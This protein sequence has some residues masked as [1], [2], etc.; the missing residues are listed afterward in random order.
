MTTP[1]ERYVKFLKVLSVN[2]LDE[3]SQY[4]TADVHFSD[5]FNDVK[6]V[7]NM[8]R[9]LLDMFK[10]V[11]PVE[12]RILHSSGDAD[13]GVIVWHFRAHLMKKPWDFHGTSVLKFGE[14]GRVSEHVDYWDAAKDFYEHLPIIGWL[15]GVFRRRLAIRTQ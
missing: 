9:V 8:R 5:P 6:G 15:L 11:G 12:F 7:E 1:I 3:L 2:N 13:I 4:V 10:H 14:C